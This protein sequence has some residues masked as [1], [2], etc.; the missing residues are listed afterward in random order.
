MKGSEILN[1][2]QL[3]KNYIPY[4][5]E[6]KKDKEL[7]LNSID[8]FDEV[9]TRNNVIAHITSSAFVVNKKRDKVLMVH[10]NI[11]NSWSWTGG[12]AD[13]EE[14]LLAV[15]IREVKEETGIEKVLPVV[16]DIFSLEVL[17]VMG[18]IKRGEY[19]SPHLHLSLSY[20]IEGDE[21]EPLKVKRDENSA[22]RWI[23]IDE[24]N[25]YSNEAHMQK[26]YKKIIDKMRALAN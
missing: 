3:I 5:D 8:T 4:N 18:H 1:W 7:I 11:Y 14:D 26:I 2:I 12:H 10:H 25:K 21:R 17:P 20:L 22:V 13:G 16:S 23:P 19:V 24:I 9:L 6:E 15:A